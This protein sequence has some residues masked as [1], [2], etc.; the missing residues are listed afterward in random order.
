MILF[1]QNV[2]MSVDL[3]GYVYDVTSPK[4]STFLWGKAVLATL[5]AIP[6]CLTGYYSNLLSAHERVS[7]C[8]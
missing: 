8:F 5:V 4:T 6:A 1:V 2:K 7:V 3:L